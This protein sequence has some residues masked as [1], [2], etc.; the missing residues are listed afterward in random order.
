MTL[1]NPQ[2]IYF[3]SAWA[4]SFCCSLSFP[5]TDG[6]V[7]KCIK[8]TF[9]WLTVCDCAAVLFSDIPTLIYDIC[10]LLLFLLLLLIA[11]LMFEK[12]QLD[13]NVC[14]RVRILA[15]I[16]GKWY[17]LAICYYFLQMM[18]DRDREGLS[19]LNVSY[20]H[21]FIRKLVWEDEREWDCQRQ[22]IPS[23]RFNA[24]TLYPCVWIVQT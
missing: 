10:L 15:L 22:H 8:V 3:A 23:E 18:S 14:L 19:F 20:T 1:R 24:L 13:G 21:T 7:L 16:F 4:S 5:V 12:W 17:F 9:S 6:L 2:A 11:K